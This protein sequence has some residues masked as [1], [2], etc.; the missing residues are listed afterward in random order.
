MIDNELNK[1]LSDK[2]NRE[3]LMKQQED[4]KPVPLTLHQRLNLW[5]PITLTL[6]YD[7]CGQLHDCFDSFLNLPET[8]LAN[9]M[10]SEQLAIICLLDRLKA[11]RQ[12]MYLQYDNQ[13]KLKVSLQYSDAYIFY[14]AL[15]EFPNAQAGQVLYTIFATI[16]RAITNHTTSSLI[17][18]TEY[19]ISKRW[20]NN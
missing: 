4:F 9:S 7:Q 11:W 15:T 2:K 14:K 6:T 13:K 19:A 3:I 10:I 20:D 17:E 1:V 12:K 8:I 16:D 18:S 5:Q